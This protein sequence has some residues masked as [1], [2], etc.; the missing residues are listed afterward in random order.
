MFK[1]APVTQGSDEI[2]QITCKHMLWLPSHF[3][4]AKVS[5]ASQNN[6]VVWI[7][8]KLGLLRADSQSEMITI[9]MQHSGLLHSGIQ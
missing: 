9:R 5:N 2:V 7:L 3:A 8:D 6:S 4:D 1:L